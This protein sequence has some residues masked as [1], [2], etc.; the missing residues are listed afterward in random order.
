MDIVASFPSL[1]GT[2]LPTEEEI[3]PLFFEKFPE[4]WT[5]D[6]DI[7]CYIRDGEY[8]RLSI[9]ANCRYGIWLWYRYSRSDSQEENYIS[10][11][12][13][14]RLNQYVEVVEDSL[15]LEGLYL[16]PEQA[17][18]A[19]R[20]FLNLEGLRSDKISWLSEDQIPKGKHWLVSS[21]CL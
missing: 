14:E 19:V 11:G 17:W 5:E 21:D 10:L 16:P 4:A 1:Y 6:A 18:L 7:T 9:V 15:T 2:S 13:P 20:D 8:Y 3:E 12:D